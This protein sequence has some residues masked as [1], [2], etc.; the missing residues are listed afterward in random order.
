M[1]SA[2]FEAYR[3]AFSNTM[4]HPLAEK[5]RERT[6]SFWKWFWLVD[7][8][9]LRQRVPEEL[10]VRCR[11]TVKEVAED[12]TAA[13]YLDA[14]GHAGAA[15]R[16]QGSARARVEEALK[17]AAREVPGAVSPRAKSEGTAP[18]EPTVSLRAG[19]RQLRRDLATLRPFASSPAQL[20]ALRV[21]RLTILVLAVVV[22]PASLLYLWRRPTV[23]AS[24][25]FGRYPFLAPHNAIDG[26]RSTEWLLENG[27]TGWLEVRFPSRRIQHVRWINA[28]NIA[29]D[30][31][32]THDFRIELWRGQEL[33]A[34]HE[35]S[36]PF[37]PS[38]VWNDVAIAGKKITR[39]RFVVNSFHNSGGGLAE[40]DWD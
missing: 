36:V 26:D 37:S 21:R 6:K 1:P 22:V 28:K 3:Q 4:K 14:L 39:L 34:S 20:W 32:G 7:E 17:D 24:S 16:L 18:G 33:V 15:R 30:P 31:R 9:A 2:H 38:P 19:A 13:G 5:L 12:L 40:L 8:E 27:Q 23:E 29:A 25:Y 10:G 11:G 35:G